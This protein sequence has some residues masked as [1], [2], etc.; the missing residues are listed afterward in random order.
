MHHRTPLALILA[1][2]ALVGCDDS[3]P[4]AAEDA[5]S[6]T[7]SHSASRANSQSA[8]LIEDVGTVPG[9]FIHSATLLRTANNV[10]VKLTAWAPPP[11]TATMWAAIFNVPGACVQEQ[12]EPVACGIDDLLGNPDTE[13]SLVRAGGRVIGGGPVTMTGHVREG[14]T[15]EALFGPGLLYPMTAEIHFIFRLHGP[16]IPTMVD[17]Q[18]HY[19]GGGCGVQ[20]CADAGAAIFQPPM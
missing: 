4:T 2:F 1:S 11:N 8:D 7:F 20:S 18:I 12:D 13:P 17:N 15:S 16:Q 3:L 9:A 14:D 6:P 19:V 10:R 5:T